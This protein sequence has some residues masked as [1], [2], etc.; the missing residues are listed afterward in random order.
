M[1]C[2][3]VVFCVVTLSHQLK[4]PREEKV[5]Q[6]LGGGGY[7]ELSQKLRPSRLICITLKVLVG[8]YLLSRSRN[9][10]SLSKG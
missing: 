7:Q 10:I 1:L 6:N 4:N 9:I 8:V 5:S 2:F 3:L